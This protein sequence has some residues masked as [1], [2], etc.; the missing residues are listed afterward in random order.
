MKTKFLLYVSV[1]VAGVLIASPSFALQSSRPI[2]TDSR[3]RTARYNPNEV[4]NFIGHYGYQSLIEFSAEEEIQS[5]SVG[6]SVAW[7]VV[8]SGNKLFIKP[9][10]Q[11]AMTNMTVVTTRGMYQFEL[12]AE[13]TENIRD[14]DMIFVLRFVYPDDQGAGVS[15]YINNVEIPDLTDPEV[16]KTLNFNYTVSGIEL[17]APIRV[18]DDGEFTYFQFRDRNSEVP[19]FYYVDPDGTEGMINFRTRGDYI[20]VE[21]VA[22][23]FTLRSGPY[24]LCVFNEAMPM[25]PR[26]APIKTGD[27]FQ[28]NF[29]I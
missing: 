7:Q 3:I 16:L 2:A 18:F 4:Y 25:P 6:D 27:W 19:A 5:V 10:E 29:G 8:P 1:C 15:N 20:V 11:D 14:K 12:H 24:V 23:V 17:A 21:R 22:P 13:E 28:R 9:V 26:I